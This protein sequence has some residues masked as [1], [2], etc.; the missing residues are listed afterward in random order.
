VRDIANQRDAVGRFGW[1]AQVPTLHQFSGDAYLNETGITNPEFPDEHCPQGNC[2][3]LACNPM[4]ELNDDGSGVEEFDHFMRFLA[5]PPRPKP[6]ANVDAGRRIFSDAGCTRCHWSTFRTGKSDSPA[7]SEVTFHPYSDFLLHDM[8]SL[9]DGVELGGA[10]GNEFR[11]APLWGVRVMTR[12]LHDGRASTLDEAI[13]AH[14]GQARR[15]RDRFA[16]LSARDQAAL[17]EFLESL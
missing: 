9:G 13:L 2:D 1:K 7:L 4:P 5:P 11:T 12:F 6:T 17:I 3:L 15:S 10:R 14:D 16:E 8:G